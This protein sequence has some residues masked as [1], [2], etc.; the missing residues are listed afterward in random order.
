VDEV[1]LAID[2]CRRESAALREPQTAGVDRGETRPVHRDADL[3][4]HRL[5]LVTRQ[6]DRELCLA[7]RTDDIEHGPLLGKRLLVEELDPA[8]RLG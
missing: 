7:R 8:R 1:A 5:D 6:H 2:V 4:E 3:P